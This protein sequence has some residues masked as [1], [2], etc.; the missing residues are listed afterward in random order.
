MAAGDVDGFLRIL[1][2]DAVFFPPNVAP[3][4][5]AAV[6]P[7]ISEFLNGYNV[8]F[9]EHRHDEVLVA[10]QWALLRTSFRW[11]VTPLLSGDAFVRLGNTVRVFRQDSTQSWRLAREIWTTY[12]TV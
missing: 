12:P 10:E 11:R 4:S 6:A 1:T 5:G 7:W 9:Q 3:K 8:E 2:P